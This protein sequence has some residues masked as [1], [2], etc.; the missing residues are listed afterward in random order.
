MG[1]A[2]KHSGSCTKPNYYYYYY[3]NLPEDLVSNEE[4]VMLGAELT[5]TLKIPLAWHDDPSLS[6]D[7]LH[8]KRAHIRIFQLRFER[9]LQMGGVQNQRK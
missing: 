4:H 3:K 5:D 2:L 6:L 9:L 1:T 7:G 8:H